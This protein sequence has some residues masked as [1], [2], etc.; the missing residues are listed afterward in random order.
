MGFF[1]DNTTGVNPV[2]NES[3][4]LFQA[5]VRGTL[6]LL[7]ST[8]M[9]LVVCVGL[10]PGVMGFNGKADTYVAYLEQVADHEYGLARSYARST[11]LEHNHVAQADALVTK[12]LGEERCRQAKGLVIDSSVDKEQQYAE[13]EAAGQVD[14]V[15]KL[16]RLLNSYIQDRFMICLYSWSVIWFSRLLIF[17]VSFLCLAGLMA[18]YFFIGEAHARM[19]QGEGIMPLPERAQW[20]GRAL[21]WGIPIIVT[22]PAIPIPFNSAIVIPLSMLLYC[23]VI[24][25]FRSNFLEF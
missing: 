15:S 10:I 11:T 18:A 3:A 13:R 8:A 16:D 21:I 7:A 5:I 9:V 24:H 22:I 14:V 20:A 12:A 4:S 2:S 23:W 1:K 17:F 6:W 25:L 19:K